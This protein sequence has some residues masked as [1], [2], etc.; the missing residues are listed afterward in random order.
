MEQYYEQ[1]VVNHN[2]EEKMRKTK[3]FTFAKMACIVL[4][5]FVLM[6]SMLF[7]TDD[8]FIMWLFIFI[9]IAVPFIIA[10]IIL[11][12]VN[13]RNNTEYDYIIDDEKLKI[14]AIYFREQRK[15]K[16]SIP[17]RAIE[18]VGVFESEGYKKIEQTAQKKILALVNF[19]DEDAIVYV[20][21]NSLKGKQIIFLEPDRGFLI[22]LKRVVSAITVFDKSMAELEKKF[23]KEESDA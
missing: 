15:L 17:L 10:A 11:G 12:R 6:T 23:N 18:S 5:V 20:L 13:K 9:A 8:S 2:I 19:D 3:I 22:A 1:N 14:S 7:M 21:Y 16:H 4:A